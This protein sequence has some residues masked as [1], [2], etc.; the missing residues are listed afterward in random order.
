MKKDTH[1]SPSHEPSDEWVSFFHP[2]SI[3]LPTPSLRR[4]GG[5]IGATLPTEMAERL[6]LEAGDRMLA[7]ETDSGILLREAVAREI[8][9]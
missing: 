4:A 5:S 6:H 8:R 7:V 1:T 9:S 2:S 3:L